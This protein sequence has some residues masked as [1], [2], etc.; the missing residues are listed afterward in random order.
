VG[1]R[2]DKGKEKTQW[3]WR[4]G[5][6]RG[7]KKKMTRGEKMKNNMGTLIKKK[8]TFSQTGAVAKSYD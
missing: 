4:L 3:E 6:G 2:R 1:E 8:I 5:R 7:A